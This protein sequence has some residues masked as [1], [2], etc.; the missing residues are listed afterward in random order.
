MREDCEDIQVDAE[1]EAFYF[2]VHD[3]GHES[4]FARQQNKLRIQVENKFYLPEQKTFLFD[5]SQFVS[6][7]RDLSVSEMANSNLEATAL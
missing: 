4:I 1:N 5:S 7:L 3:G 6:F 2:C